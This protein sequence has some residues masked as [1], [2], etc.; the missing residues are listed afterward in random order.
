M[1]L[2]RCKKGHYYDGDKYQ[3]CPHCLE[4]DHNLQQCARHVLKK[5]ASLK[6]NAAAAK[7]NASLSD[8]PV[9]MP[10]LSL[11]DEPVTMPL[12]HL[13][14][15]LAEMVP[16]S[17]QDD[18]ITMPLSSV[19]NLSAG[20]PLHAKTSTNIDHAAALS[21]ERRLTVGWLV[22]I[23]GKDFG[24]SFAV[25]SGRNYIGRSA[26]MDIALHKENEAVKEKHAVIYYVPK[27][28]KFIAE[29]G[30]T[31]DLFYL[32]GEVVMN[33]VEIKKKDVLTVGNTR[34][35]FVPFCGENFNWEDAGKTYRE[36]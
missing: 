25:K 8:N 22:C 34:L 1:I 4:E 26:K 14:D 36:E 31:R 6:D 13:S 9:T 20:M 15:E 33:P 2:K 18:P 24:I 3:K 29:P 35:M 12:R 23:K 17:L 32:N 16:S 10:L 7:T 27:Q 21:Q 30:E 11:P 19:K 28:K 5:S